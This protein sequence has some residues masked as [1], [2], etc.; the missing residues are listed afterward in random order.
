MNSQYTVIESKCDVHAKKLVDLVHKLLFYE[1]NKNIYIYPS[2]F[3]SILIKY[4]LNTFHT[5]INV[6]LF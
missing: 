4:G 3:T 2:I 1:R 6:N 5:L